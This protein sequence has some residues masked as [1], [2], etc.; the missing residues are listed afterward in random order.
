MKQL[1]T[2]MLLIFT[3]FN[4][5]T[6]AIAADFKIKQSNIAIT[7]QETT[8]KQ[9]RTKKTVKRVLHLRK[10]HTLSLKRL[11]PQIDDEPSFLVGDS[12]VVTALCVVIMVMGLAAVVT[13]IVTSLLWVWGIGLA[14]LLG[15]LLA[16]IFID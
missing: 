10:R 2:L 5:T 11:V 15:V 14:L 16:V 9:S 6:Q 4:L 13:A 12:F 3:L 1:Y 8:H 7:K